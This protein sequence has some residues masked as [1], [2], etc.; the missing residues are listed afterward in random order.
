MLHALA[1][2]GRH[3]LLRG[4]LCA[5]LPLLLVVGSVA[6]D[7]PGGCRPAGPAATAQG[8]VPAPIS[9]D[10]LP[11]QRNARAAFF[12][13]D[14]AGSFKP[15]SPR[16][17]AVNRPQTHLLASLEA[18]RGPPRRFADLPRVGA[19]VLPAWRPPSAPAASR[20]ARG[21]RAPPAAA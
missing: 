4:V 10:P 5:L 8:P 7:R 13:E 18:V 15:R 17:A 3:R 12:G 11:H 21:Q 16:E 1:A 20:G 2:L 19:A 9:A 14:P 6:G